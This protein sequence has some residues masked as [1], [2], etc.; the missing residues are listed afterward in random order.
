MKTLATQPREADIDSFT[1]EMCT[2]LDLTG[3][4]VLCITDVEIS[5]PAPEE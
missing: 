3:S 5:I 4:T 1:E 2:V